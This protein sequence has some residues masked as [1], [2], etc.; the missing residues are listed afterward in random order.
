MRPV[1]TLVLFFTV[2]G[3]MLG[4]LTAGTMFS[5]ADWRPNLALD[6]EGGT[7]IILTPRTADADE[8]TDEQVDQAIEIIRQRVDSS[9]V[10]EAEI[11]SQGAS[12][13]VVGLPGEP[14]EE[15]LD[16]VRQSA[17]MRFRSFLTEAGPGPID[18]SAMQ[19]MPEDLDL[20]DLDPQDVE[21]LTEFEENVIGEDGDE[22]N[23]D[24]GSGTDEDGEDAGGASPGVTSAAPVQAATEDDDGEDGATEDADQ[25]GPG[26][27]VATDQASEDG[28]Q[29]EGPTGPP[30]PDDVHEAAF[31]AADIDGDG[32][33]SDT[34]D[35]EPA[36]ASDQAWITEQVLY[37]FYTLD[38][39]NPE[40][41]I[42]G[43]GDDPDKALA[44]CSV[45]GASKFILGPMEIPGTDIVTASSGFQTTE[46]GVMT[47]NPNVTMEFNSEGAQTFLEVTQRISQPQFQ[48]AGTHRFAMVL[49]GLVLT[50]PTV[51]D[52]I[53]RGQAEISGNMTTDSA[54]TLASQLNFGS[55]PIE[56]EV[57]S[58]EQI[59]ATLGSEQLQRGV[60]AGLIGLALVVVYALI[61]YRGLAIISLASLTL[62][63]LLTYLVIAL[64]SW[65]MGYR[66]SLAGVAGLI[67]AIGIIA[68]S[69][70]VYFERIRDEVREG[71]R[72]PDA[73]EQG[74]KRARRTILASDAV[75]LMG[76][77][78][79]YFVAVGGVR[80]FAVTLGLITL[81]DLIVFVFF[82]HPFMKVLIRT[83]F[84]AEGSKMSGLDPEHLGAVVSAYRGRGQIRTKAEREAV[85]AGAQ[86]VAGGTI[87]E[88]RRA[89]ALAAVSAQASATADEGVA[90]HADPGGE[91]DAST[92]AK[93][94]DR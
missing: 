15:T 30:I 76:A 12:N 81:I 42:G 34:P 74:W 83:R 31:A 55:L 79:L 78:V 66:L 25:D 6:L 56:F 10:A 21:D 77:V 9:G 5:D 40:N 73:V 60:L 64:M 86:E 26:E 7:Q 27:D 57:Q 4:T 93:G 41:L 44:A 72:L 84:F 32:E 89:A 71:R 87:A 29:G 70:I 61:Q 85:K 62:G 19:E 65:Q 13:I 35:S 14:S 68:D 75:N 43:G 82:T 49:D 54:R 11:S 37:D 88:R 36:H 28:T 91:V 23:G 90:E 16:L 63:G 33:L 69:F 46:T 67:V 50:A 59:S 20:E 52:P 94:D 17:Q 48:Q 22:G 51:T 58:E 8:I 92:A 2:L 80:G 45:D 53:P 47:N 38:C 1:R 24:E 3:V 18:P 39:T